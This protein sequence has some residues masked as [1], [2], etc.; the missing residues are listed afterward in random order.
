MTDPTSASSSDSGFQKIPKRRS[1]RNRRQE[2]SDGPMVQLKKA[3]A[4]CKDNGDEKALAIGKSKKKR[5]LVSSPFF[6][7]EV[8]TSCLYVVATTTS[9]KQ[10]EIKDHRMRTLV[11]SNLVLS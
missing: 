6:P 3:K 2:A 4:A 10:S 8:N 7:H 11:L 1:A 9:P 5:P